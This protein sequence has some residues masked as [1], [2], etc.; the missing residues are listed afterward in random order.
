MTWTQEQIE[1]LK[2]LLKQ[3]LSTREIAERLGK[4]ITRNAVIGKTHRLGL[5]KA[6]KQTDNSSPSDV[7]SLSFGSSK[8]TSSKKHLSCRWPI[9]HPGAKD[10][11]FCGD[12]V[13]K[14]RSYCVKHCSIAYRNLYFSE[15]T[16]PVTSNK[17]KGKTT[18][19]AP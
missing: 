9:G 8:S 13:V 19:P 18:R 16:T 1:L 7:K 11:H 15:P 10:F 6:K 2:V 17:N 4:G 5:S 14:G 3:N 12:H